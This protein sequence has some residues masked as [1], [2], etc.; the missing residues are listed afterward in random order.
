MITKSLKNKSEEYE[1]I[2]DKNIIKT[3]FDT[4]TLLNQKKRI[5]FLFPEVVDYNKKTNEL[6]LKKVPGNSINDIIKSKD[7]KINE[8]LLLTGKNLR[9][10]HN[11]LKKRP[12][13]KE[14]IEN[15]KEEIKS[16]LKNWDNFN[17]SKK[18][19]I[20]LNKKIE[21]LSQKLEL[22]NIKYTG[23]HDDFSPPNI[24]S[25][26]KNVY[27][28][29]LAGFKY[30]L[31]YKDITELILCIKMYTKS[32]FFTDKKADYLISSFLK[33]YQET[34]DINLK[35]FKIYKCLYFMDI[36]MK[37]FQFYSILSIKYINLR[38]ILRVLKKELKKELR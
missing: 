6:Q 32:P 24:I 1:R 12:A 3:E 19:I 37:N 5:S 35:F 7:P 17:L 25:D 8:I 16:Y 33:G 15:I 18:T 34:N 23:I 21:E 10:M 13:K 28:I 29:D 30:D 38:L 27:F 2:R 9:L 11:E 31:N 4:L 26:N 14:D 22:S 20:I 36:Y